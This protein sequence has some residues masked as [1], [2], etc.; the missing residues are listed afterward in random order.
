MSHQLLN[1]AN[2]SSLVEEMGCEGMTQTVGKNLN[3]DSHSY[4]PNGPV[5]QRKT[6]GVYP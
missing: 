1:Y 4:L 5:N 6:Y 3:P 2:I